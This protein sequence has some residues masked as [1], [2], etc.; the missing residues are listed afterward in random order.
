MDSSQYD[1]ELKEDARF[2]TKCGTGLRDKENLTALPVVSIILSIIGIIGDWAP[3]GYTSYNVYD[4]L[5][6][7]KCFS[8]LLYAAIIVALI[9]LIKQKNK[10]A[11]IA[12]LIPCAYLII[13]AVNSMYNAR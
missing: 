4:G 5:I 6:F 10:F 7:R 11:F 12:G 3:L 8:I 9:V 13:I 2:C 1:Q